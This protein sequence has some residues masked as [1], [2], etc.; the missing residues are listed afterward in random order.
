[1]DFKLVI[2][3][4]S[5]KYKFNTHLIWY[6][7]VNLLNQ[8]EE[9]DLSNYVPNGE[10]DLIDLVVERNVVF[11]SCCEGKSFLIH[12][13]SIWIYCLM[14]YISGKSEP[15]PDITF[16]IILRRRPLFYGRALYWFGLVGIYS[17]L[18]R[19]SFFSSFQFDPSLCTDHRN[20]PHE[21]LHAIWFRREGDTGH[22]HSFVNDG[23]SY[24][25]FF[26]RNQFHF[27]F[28]NQLNMCD[29]LLFIRRSLAKVCLQLQRNSH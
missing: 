12:H 22:H 23:V 28:R 5:P 13:S 6:T 7:K 16:T 10:W 8:A 17:N 21:F 25:R 26:T 18:G 20:S 3:F 29:W 4:C 27:L 19:H 24:G 1:M 11:Y 14:V 15:Y 9:G 2:L